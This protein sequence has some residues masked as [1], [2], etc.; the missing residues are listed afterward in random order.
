MADQAE[1]RGAAGLGPNLGLS[2]LDVSETGVRLV[3]KEALRPGRVVSLAL[4]G[5]S[6]ARPLERRGTVAW[7]M[8]LADGSHCVGVSFHTHLAYQERNRRRGRLD[9]Q[10][11]IRVRQRELATP[12]FDYLMVSPDELR[13]LLAGTGWRLAHTID[14]DDTYIAVI[15]KELSERLPARQRA[16]RGRAA[17]SGG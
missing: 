6:N 14:S 5:A 15:D 13:T 2:V 7:S 10:I 16:H 17:R 8:P 11:R 4:E 1:Q 12:W 9:G 3:V